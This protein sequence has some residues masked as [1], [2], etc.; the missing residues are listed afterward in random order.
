MIIFGLLISIAAVGTLC[1]LLFNLAVVALP[2]FLG[3]NL[4]I[5]AS[6]PMARVRAGWAL[7]SPGF[8]VPA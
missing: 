4:G 8:S 6:G 1:W 5:W 3:V 7:L 2:A